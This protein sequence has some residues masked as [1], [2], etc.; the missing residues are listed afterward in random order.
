MSST[1]PRSCT[2]YSGHGEP[3]VSMME[4]VSPDEPPCSPTGAEAVP[5][6]TIASRDLVCARPD[7]DIAEVVR[8]MI[9]NRVGCVPVVDERRHPIG[10]ITKF[11]IVEQIEAMLRSSSDG[12]PLPPDLAARNADEIMLPLAF[13]LDEN[14]TIAHAAA[15][16]TSE[17]VH[18][19]LVVSTSGQL[20][21]IASSKDIVSWLV[22]NDAMVLEPAV[23]TWR[24]VDE[25]C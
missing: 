10:V 5:L 15:M 13:T 16:M 17:D 11:D 18:H 4:L 22:Q 8:L 7:L 14:A 2:V 3:T 21:G 6:M 20:V 1:Q 24:P 25:T 12:S 19:V 23:A 9:R